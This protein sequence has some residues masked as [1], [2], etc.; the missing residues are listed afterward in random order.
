MEEKRIANITKQSEN[1][2]LKTCGVRHTS[3]MKTYVVNFHDSEFY[4]YDDL[5]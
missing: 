5:R 3:A 4:A 2:E 1:S